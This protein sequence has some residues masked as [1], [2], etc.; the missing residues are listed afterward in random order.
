MSETQRGSRLR[1]LGSRVALLA[2]LGLAFTLVAPEIPRDQLVVY[3]V[4]PGD[5]LLR[6]AA[7]YTRD[8]D[9]EP[10]SGMSM[11]PVGDGR[12]SFE[13]K[14]S[15]PNGRYVIEVTL[16]RQAPDGKVRETSFVRKVTLE[17]GE[18]VLPLEDAP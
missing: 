17:G 5:K 1:R 16:A 9:A 2:G 13:H 7:S 3:R 8:G 6:L 12:A 4:G 10:R 15:L 11:S 14:V 18:T